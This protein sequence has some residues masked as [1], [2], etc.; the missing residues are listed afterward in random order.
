MSGIAGLQTQRLQAGPNRLC[1]PM[2]G[3]AFDGS[4]LQL[5]DAL[6]AGGA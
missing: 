2:Q 5:N 4:Q 1:G 3:L 6:D